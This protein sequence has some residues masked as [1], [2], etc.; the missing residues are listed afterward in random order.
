MSSS[1][2]A[3]MSKVSVRAS[4]SPTTPNAPTTCEFSRGHSLFG[5]RAQNY[6]LSTYPAMLRPLRGSSAS[7]GPFFLEVC[8]GWI[9]R[10]FLDHE[11]DGSCGDPSSTLKL[12]AANRYAS[13]V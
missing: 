10:P 8:L 12:F 4:T 7:W 6:G 1:A 5:G 11:G 3:S 2:C 9:R 13:V